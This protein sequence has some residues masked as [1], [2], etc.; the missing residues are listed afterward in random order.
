M[1]ELLRVAEEVDELRRTCAE[2]RTQNDAVK[3]SEAQTRELEAG[4]L[5]QP[6]PSL[7]FC[8]V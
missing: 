4:V 8:L 3:S 7:A 6:Q 2:L 5:Q 1:T